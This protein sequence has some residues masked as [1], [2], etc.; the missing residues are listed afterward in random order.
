ML[1]KTNIVDSGRGGARLP[2]IA[3]TASS[4]QVSSGPSGME[5]VAVANKS[6]LEKKASVYGGV[7]KD[8][9]SARERGLPFKVMKFWFLCL[10]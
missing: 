6:I 9:N 5:I 10:Y 8:L 2:Q 3:S 7:V 1:P 4:P